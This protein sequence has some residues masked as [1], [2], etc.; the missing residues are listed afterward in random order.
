MLTT[1]ALCL[2]MAAAGG[3]GPAAMTSGVS[4]A[5]TSTSTD[6]LFMEVAGMSN[7]AEIATSHL[8]LR[9]SGNAAVR[10]Y[11][12]KMIT[13][14]TRAQDQ[15]NALAARKGTKLTDRLGADQRVQGDKLSTLSGAAFDAEYKKVQVAGHD[16]TLTLIKMYRSFG[17]DADALAYA[18]KTQPIVAGH[19][20]MAQGLPDE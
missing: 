20:E 19:L 7:L 3:A 18:A 14:H 16:L 15:L 10:A 5:Q 8:A 9:K 4:T 1:L 12:Q 6:V 17:Q 2:P 11:A 13:D